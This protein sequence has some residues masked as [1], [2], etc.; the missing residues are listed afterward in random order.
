MSWDV[1]DLSRRLPMLP[2][3]LAAIVAAAGQAGIARRELL[4]FAED[5]AKMGVAFDTTAAD[6][7]QTM[8]TWRTAFRMLQP[9]VVELADKINYLGNTGPASVAKISDV[10]NRIGALGDVAGLKSGPLA[11]LG[12]TVAGMG[13]ESEVS[14]TGIKNLLLTLASGEG[15]TLRQRKA[16]AALSLDATQVA[17]ALQDDAGG[18]ILM[19]L[20]RMRELPKAAQAAKM[21]QLFG[22]ESIGAIAPLLTNLELLEKNLGKGQRCAAVRR[23]DGQGNTRRAWRPPRTPCS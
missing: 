21:T 8:A 17:T 23:L 16:F 1:Q 9:E 20:R 13:I 12:A 11:A 3:D 19:V 4:G 15:A 10:V 2:E 22:R 7:G 14:A 6:A 5:A 18:A